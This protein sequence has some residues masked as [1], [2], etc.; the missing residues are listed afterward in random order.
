[1][2]FH[3]ELSKAVR[4]LEAARVTRDALIF[5]ASRAGMTTRQIA[6]ASGLSHQRVQQLIREWREGRPKRLERSAELVENIRL[7][8]TPIEP[9]SMFKDTPPKPVPKPKRRRNKT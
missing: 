3:K 7:G 1:M 2:D 8:G 6:D 4:E 5:E 9:P